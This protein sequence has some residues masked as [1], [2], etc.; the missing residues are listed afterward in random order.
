VSTAVE[1]WDT[2][3]GPNLS[4]NILPTKGR[5]TVILRKDRDHSV[6][7]VRFRKI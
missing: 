4:A 3:N 7:W 1:I 2:I 5:A 6:Q